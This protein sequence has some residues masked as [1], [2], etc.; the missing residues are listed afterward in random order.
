MIRKQYEVK[1]FKRIVRECPDEQISSSVFATRKIVPCT[2]I[3]HLL[4]LRI[5]A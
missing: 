4:C 1:F 5:N 2:I 3:A